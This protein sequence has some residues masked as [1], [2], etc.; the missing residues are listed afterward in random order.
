MWGIVIKE[1]LLF[2]QE[3]LKMVKQGIVTC[4][5]TRNVRVYIFIYIY[6]QLLKKLSLSA[7]GQ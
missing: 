2:G 5:S 3:K 1:T 6:V 4:A 7:V